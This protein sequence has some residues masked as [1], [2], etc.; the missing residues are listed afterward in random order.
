MRRPPRGLRVE[1]LRPREADVLRQLYDAYVEELASFGAAYRRRRDGTW[2]YRPPGGRWGAD[3][4]TYWLED[5]DEHVVLVFRLR[6]AVVG[7]AMIG[8]RPAVWMPAGTDACIAEFVINGVSAEFYELGAAGL[9]AA[10]GRVLDDPLRAQRM[11]A[12]GRKAMINRWEGAAF[13][14]LWPLLTQQQ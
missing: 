12:E 4:L 11:A 9:A 8:L 10:I 14:H 7:F 13:S 6:S 3:H 2:Q 5:R 1:R